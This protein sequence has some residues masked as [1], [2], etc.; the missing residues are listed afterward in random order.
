MSR[1]LDS[2][3]FQFVFPL[4]IEN[5]ADAL[6]QYLYNEMPAS[7]ATAGGAPRVSSDVS[8]MKLK[9]LDNDLVVEIIYRNK[10]YSFNSDTFGV[11]VEELGDD[12]DML[13][14]E[15][16]A[17]MD[18][19]IENYASP[20]LQH[21][22][23]FGINLFE[24]NPNLKR[25]N[26]DGDPAS[27]SEFA[28]LNFDT[29]NNYTFYLPHAKSYPAIAFRNGK[30]LAEM[31]SDSMHNYPDSWVLHFDK[32]FYTAEWND[33]EGIKKL[34]EFACDREASQVTYLLQYPNEIIG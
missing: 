14:D 19:L 21:R 11:L 16:P 10:P 25:I 3:E 15:D 22:A 2:L 24:S 28:H 30:S 27:M 13:Q 33:E 23:K 18:D 17:L 9:N 1:E 12:Y 26:G 29:P 8:S 5:F 31:L 20:M 6:W 34:I 32:V 4:G 7:Y